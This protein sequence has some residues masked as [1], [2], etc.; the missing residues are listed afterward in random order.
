MHTVDSLQMGHL[1]WHTVCPA[2]GVKW[3]IMVPRAAHAG[4]HH[5]SRPTPTS[6]PTSAVGYV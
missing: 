6:G 5:H 3:P 4:L 1:K 2:H